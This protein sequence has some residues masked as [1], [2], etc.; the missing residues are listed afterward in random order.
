LRDVLTVF[1]T[2]GV[3]VASIMGMDDRMRRQATIIRL[4][5]ERW[6]RSR[7]VISHWEKAARRVR[8]GAARQ[9]RYPY[10]ELAGP[11]RTG[12]EPDDGSTSA[13]V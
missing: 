4:E 6:R 10:L 11:R 3:R 12:D 13:A 2:F 1:A 7:A 5:G 8:R 9:E